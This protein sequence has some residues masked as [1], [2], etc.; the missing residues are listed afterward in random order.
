VIKGLR[1]LF[2]RRTT[3]R[4][5]KKILRTLA[6]IGGS[7]SCVSGLL[8]SPLWSN[9]VG[10]FCG[11]GPFHLTVFYGRSFAMFSYFCRAF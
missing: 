3:L 9:V 11:L 7:P 10:E 1:M 4:P 6:G 2:A 5:L 8:V